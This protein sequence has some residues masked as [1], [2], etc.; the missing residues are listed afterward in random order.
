MLAPLCMS[1]SLNRTSAKYYRELC[2]SHQYPYPYPSPFHSSFNYLLCEFQI[3]EAIW[4]YTTKHVMRILRCLKVTCRLSVDWT[5]FSILC[6]VRY[7]LQTMLLLNDCSNHRIHIHAPLICTLGSRPNVLT[8][9]LSILLFLCLFDFTV[10]YTSF[11]RN[12]RLF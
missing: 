1:F 7:I 6:C 8:L 4:L 3:L 2:V 11:L 9:F 12:V 10:I 5:D